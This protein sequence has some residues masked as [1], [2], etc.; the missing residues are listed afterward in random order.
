MFVALTIVF[1]ILLMKL[2]GTILAPWWVV[3][4]ICVAIVILGMF[5]SGVL[6]VRVIRED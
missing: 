5:K 4:L 1:G 6:V 2:S 3:S